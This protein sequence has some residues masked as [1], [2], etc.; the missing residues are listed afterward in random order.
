VPELHAVHARIAWLP[1]SGVAVAGGC[2]SALV[3]QCLPDLPHDK[4]RFG[5]TLYNIIGRKAASLP[6][7]NYSSAMKDAD[8]EWEEEK[9][10]RFIAD[11][12]EV[13]P[14]NN[15]R[16]YGGLA[17]ADDRAIIIAFLRSMTESRP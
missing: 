7:Y 10:D 11:P 6:N 13:M 15:M 14:N 8:F 9:L 16:P 12:D 3:Q 5:P 4:G 1:V 17:S 2:I